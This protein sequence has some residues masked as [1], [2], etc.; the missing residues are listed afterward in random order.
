MN[1][2]FEHNDRENT[3][4]QETQSS[5]TPPQV[6]EVQ[7]NYT[8]EW[9]GAPANGRR[10]KSRKG[11]FIAVTA[12]VLAVLTITLSCALLFAD[13]NGGGL[14]TPGSTQGTTSG[15]TAG[16]VNQTVGITEEQGETYDLKTL[17]EKCSFSCAT[18]RTTVRNGYSIGSGFVITSDGYIVTNHHVIEDY[19]SIEVIF[20]DGTEYDAELIGSDDASDL[21]V[22]KIDANDLTPIELGNSD[23]LSVGDPVVA[24]GTPY[25]INLAGTLTQGVISG[26][27]REVTVSSGTGTKTMRLLQ[28]DSSINPGN[29]GG[30]LLNMQ[31]QVVGI[32]TL[33]LKDEYEGI[34]FA[35]PMSN[36]VEI[37]NML[38]QDGEVINRPDNDYVTVSAFLN[39]TVSE[40]NDQTIA[41]YRLPEDVPEGV[42]VVNIGSRTAAIYRA[43]VEVYD[44]ITE[45][46]GQAITSNESLKTALAACQAGDE[47]TIKVYRISRDGSTGT[48]LTFTFKL[49]A[50]Q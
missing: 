1:D 42:L 3:T 21:A 24:I 26:V 20:Y 31:G 50:A 7:P 45:F 36:A 16:E 2:N 44:I 32:N 37:I 14:F 22:L 9:N 6:P 10:R 12:V 23:A 11:I 27:N 5:L 15:G 46:N 4:P 49:D 38:I 28:T 8:Y 29:S 19:V 17:Y 41:L 48:E 40:I 43:G 35:I 39:I 33:K 25:G 13:D 18:I 34:G 47:A 30:P